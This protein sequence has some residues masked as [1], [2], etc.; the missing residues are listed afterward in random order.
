MSA[1]PDAF[2]DPAYRSRR[3]RNWIIVGLL[4]SF[5]YMTRYNL[6]ALAPTL[7]TVFGWDNNDFGV[8]ETLLPLVYGLSVVL[9][10]PLAERFGGRRAFLVGAAGVVVMNVVFGLFYLVVLG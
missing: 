3:R 6:A 8:F 4:Y 1:I 9:N 7:K 10:A 5:F 2:R